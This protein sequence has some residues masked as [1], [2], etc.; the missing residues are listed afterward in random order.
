MRRLRR[1]LPRFF[2][3]GLPLAHRLSTRLL[4][5]LLLSLSFGNQD[6]PNFFSALAAPAQPQLIPPDADGAHIILGKGVKVV[7]DVAV[8]AVALDWTIVEELDTR[9]ALVL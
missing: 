8:A 2:T 1:R 5:H 6:L 9:C 4:C 3:L 7:E